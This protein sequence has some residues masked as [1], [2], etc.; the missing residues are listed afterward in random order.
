MEESNFAAEAQ[1]LIHRLVKQYELC[2]R[3]CLSQHG[4]TAAQGYTLL[5]LPREDSVNMKQV[6]EAIGLA[7]STMTRMIDQ[8]VRKQLV[9]RK[10]D[11]E[12]RRVV[13]VHLSDKGREVRRIVER[14]IREFFNVALEEIPEDDYP[15]ILGTLERV[16]HA[17]S[18][19]LEVFCTS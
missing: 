14:E 9:C 10:P 17:M 4:V 7:G 3:A 12:D 15:I 13:L 18:R 8:L 2:D 6:S 11:E 1:R 19:A 5:A 16:N